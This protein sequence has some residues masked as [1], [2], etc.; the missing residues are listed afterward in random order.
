M[1][2]TRREFHHLTALAALTPL[3]PQTKSPPF[4]ISLAEW[5]L[6]R[7]LKS[8]AMTNLDFPKTASLDYS[9]HCI[10]YVNQFFKSKPRDA[11]YLAELKER[12]SDHGVT[13]RLIMCDDEGALGAADKTSREKAIAN[14]QAWVDAAAALGCTAIRVNASGEGTREEHQSRVAESLHALATYSD[15]FSIDVI[16]ENHGGLS[17]DG[18]W[19]AG[20]MKAADHPRVGTLPDFGNFDLGD[21]KQY[22]RYRG[23]KEMMPWAKAV[24]AKSHDF[25]EHGNETSTDYARMLKIV[26]DA[27][28][29]S[30]L[31]IE[32]EGDRLS[33]PE[34]IKATQA[35]LER[36][37]REMSE[38]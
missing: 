31:G 38:K 25:D 35:L 2:P 8:G 6:H 15:K 3:L 5:S 16:V 9:I 11:A 26:C 22:D 28:Y 30:Y 17:S 19:L 23:V 32:Y 33:E 24:S 4:L 29:H 7:A 27:G 18:S 13:S 20:V 14:H 1:S 34:G 37:R 12:C 21:G 36:V 10:E